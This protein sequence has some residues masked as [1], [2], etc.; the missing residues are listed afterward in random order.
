M[1]E[2]A[3]LCL[4]GEQRKTSENT[5]GDKQGLKN[6]LSAIVRKNLGM[7]Y[8]SAFIV[9]DDGTDEHCLE[10]REQSQKDQ[11]CGVLMSFPVN[12]KQSSKASQGRDPHDPS[13]LMH[14]ICRTRERQNERDDSGSEQLDKQD[15][16]DLSHKSEPYSSITVYD[17]YPDFKVLWK[18]I[19]YT[20]RMGPGI[21]TR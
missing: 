6:L 21:S 13:V 1:I 18:I 12:S 2:D 9:R 20:W 3:Y 7:T 19:F 5:Q 15:R 17:C 4:E 14:E 10:N 11:V 16:V 8:D